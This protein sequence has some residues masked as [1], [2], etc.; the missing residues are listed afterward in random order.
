LAETT[1]QEFL[2]RAADL[3]GVDNLA[4]ALKAPRHLV[5]AWMHGHASM[6]DRKLLLLTDFLD[7]TA[8]RK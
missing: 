2:K 3:V 8:N 7:K 1:K 5:E 6:P 4:V